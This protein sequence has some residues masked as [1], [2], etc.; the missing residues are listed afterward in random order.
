M[1]LIRGVRQLSAGVAV[2][3]G[4]AT[5]WAAPVS[6]CTDWPR[7]LPSLSRALCEQA[8][9]EPSGARSVRGVPLYQRDVRAPV[10]EELSVLP[11]KAV[12]APRRVLVMGG[13]HGDELSSASL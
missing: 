12:K 6:P 2:M 8:A 3:A 10:A 13:I 11:G 4:L 1:T 5:A 7:R 9:L